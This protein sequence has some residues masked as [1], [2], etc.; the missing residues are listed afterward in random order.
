MISYKLEVMFVFFHTPG[1]MIGR[2]R[3]EWYLIGKLSL[4]GATRKH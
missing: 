3:I 2:V 4:K 1:V